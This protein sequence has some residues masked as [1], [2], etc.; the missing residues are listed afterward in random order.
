MKIWPTLCM[1]SRHDEVGQ[2]KQQQKVDHDIE[3]VVD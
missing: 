3:E 1:A 2:A